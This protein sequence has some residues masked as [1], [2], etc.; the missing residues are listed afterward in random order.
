MMLTASDAGS[1]AVANNKEETMPF[2][3]VPD[4]ALIVIKGKLKGQDCFNTLG[5]GL[6]TPGAVGEAAL[7][8]LTSK[9]ATYWQSNMLPVLPAAYEMGLVTGAALDDSEG[10]QSEDG[11]YIGQVGALAGDT[12]PNNDTIAVAFRC[13]LRGRANRGRNYWPALLRTEVTDNEVDS[14]KVASIIGS[15]GG[16]LDDSGFDATWQWS[17]ISRKIIDV[18]GVGRAVRITTVSVNDLVLDSQRRRL[19]NRGR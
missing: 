13:N 14:T 12:L 19:P 9:V 11:S 4:G 2:Q 7:I 18:S 5:F 8:A 10:P 6:K 1:L 3:P 17:V 16:L 15:Y